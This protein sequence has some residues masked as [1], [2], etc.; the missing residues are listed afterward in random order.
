MMTTWWSLPT[1]KNK[2]QKNR[3]AADVAGRFFS[4]PGFASAVTVIARKTKGR[5]P[6]TRLG[7]VLFV[8]NATK[9]EGGP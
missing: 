4:T 7:G 3:P 5:N 6:S 9:S 1:S 8:A 2:L